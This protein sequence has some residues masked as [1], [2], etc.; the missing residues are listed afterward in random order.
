MR[1]SIVK[2]LEHAVLL[3]SG[4]HT[5]TAML[6][7]AVTIPAVSHVRARLRHDDLPTDLVL[8]YQQ[9]ANHASSALDIAPYVLRLLSSELVKVKR[10]SS[11]ATRVRRPSNPLDGPI[12]RVSLVHKPVPAIIDETDHSQKNQLV[13]TGLLGTRLSQA[14]SSSSQQLDAAIDASPPSLPD[15]RAQLEQLQVNAEREADRLRVQLCIEERLRKQCEHRILDLEGSIATLQEALRNSQQR[16]SEK[17]AAL[18]D[19]ERQVHN[20]AVALRQLEHEAMTVPALKD[21][22]AELGILNVPGRKADL[23][24]AII[25]HLDDR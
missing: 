11:D 7:M 18:A 12:F 4:P 15:L 1:S 19:V 9:H 23:V 16:A 8:L 5:S 24:H 10:P 13:L 25:K 21:R 6:E 3:A 22:C 17:D 20:Q 2:M 14:G